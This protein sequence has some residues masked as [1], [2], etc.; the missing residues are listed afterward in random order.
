[1]EVMMIL[2]RRVTQ[3]LRWPHELNLVLAPFFSSFHYCNV[4]LS[5]RTVVSRTSIL[6]RTPVYPSNKFRY[7]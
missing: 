3:M 2:M 6:F 1:M 4:E 7:S 5:N